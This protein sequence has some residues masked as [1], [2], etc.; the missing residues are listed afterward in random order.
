[1][2]TSTGTLTGSVTDPS[3]DPLSGVYVSI[4]RTG[5]FAVTDRGGW[6]TLDGPT[7]WLAVNYYHEGYKVVRQVVVLK[8][9]ET[10]TV[11]VVLEPV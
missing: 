9:G 5:R 6:Y 11:D 8:A 10:T 4:R 7:R 3:G 1:M 2:T